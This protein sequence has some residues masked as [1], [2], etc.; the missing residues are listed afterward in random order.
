ML[1]SIITIQ[2]GPDFLHKFRHK[3]Y[4]SDI[5][6]VKI[7]QNLVNHINADLCYQEAGGEG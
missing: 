6:R 3:R 7:K 1:V 2:S 5:E 4:F